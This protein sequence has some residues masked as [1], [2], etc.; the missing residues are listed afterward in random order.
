MYMK[1]T[2]VSCKMTLKLIHWRELIFAFG[3]TLPYHLGMT[4]DH[5]QED[6][7]MSQNFQSLLK[8]CVY[9]Y[10]YMYKY[11]SNEFCD[12]Q[13]I[14]TQHKS[15]TW[16]I[17][18]I[19]PCHLGQDDQLLGAPSGVV[20]AEA[21]PT[22]LPNRQR[23][24]RRILLSFWH[25]WNPK[26]NSWVD[27]NVEIPWNS[28]CVF[29]FCIMHFPFFCCDLHWRGIISWIVLLC[30]VTSVHCDDILWYILIYY[31][32][33]L[34]WHIFD[35]FVNLCILRG[36]SQL[37]TQLDASSRDGYAAMPEFFLRTP[38]EFSTRVAPSYCRWRQL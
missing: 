6:M 34:F 19:N 8:T 29:F 38:Y 4:L 24:L 16:D 32:C 37:A 9:V 22:G 15:G 28:S 1:T 36:S 5:W 20:G 17:S 2:K 31:M 26:K 7:A 14:S 12:I 35:L 11:I 23:R 27:V 30:L 18:I 3:K 33:W 21:H 13:I 25:P 10:I